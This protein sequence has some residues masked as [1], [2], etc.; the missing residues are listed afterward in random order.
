MSS[1]FDQIFRKITNFLSFIRRRHVVEMLNMAQRP[2]SSVL[3]DATILD[4]QSDKNITKS[5]TFSTKK[6]KNVVPVAI[7]TTANN[8]AA[9][10]TVFVRL[11]GHK[12]SLVCLGS[13]LIIQPKNNMFLNKPP[14]RISQQVV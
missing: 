6:D 7:E 10:S 2:Y 8:L 3:L 5:K 13:S 4:C 9:V 11:P 1:D 14:P 12:R